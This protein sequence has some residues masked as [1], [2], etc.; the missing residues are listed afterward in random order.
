[1]D[2]PYYLPFI[3]DQYYQKRKGLAS[4]WMYGVYVATSLRIS[5]IIFIPNLKFSMAILSLFP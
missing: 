4:I 1:M 5:T 3:I 2:V